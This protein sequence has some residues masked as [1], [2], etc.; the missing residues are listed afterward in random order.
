MTSRTQRNHS[1][2]FKAKVALA[3]LQGDKPLSQLAEQYDLHANQIVDWKKQLQEQAA[4]VF[5]TQSNV[6]PVDLKPLHTKIGQ[7]TL[8]NDF[9]EHVLSKAG[10][11]SVKK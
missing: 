2:I 7:L 6:V 4:T 8:E 3:A 10:L 1:P 11:L 5:G 9:L